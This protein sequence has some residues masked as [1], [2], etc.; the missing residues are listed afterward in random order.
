MVTNVLKETKLSATLCRLSPPSSPSKAWLRSTSPTA[1]T[2]TKPRSK[3][4][5]ALDTEIPNWLAPP[6]LKVA[7]KSSVPTKNPL[8][9]ANT[10]V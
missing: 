1:A 9:T 10:Y 6:V 3:I 5:A 7:T 8:P 2:S 4:L